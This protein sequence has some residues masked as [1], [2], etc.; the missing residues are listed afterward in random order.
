MLK[1]VLGG[2]YRGH[3]GIEYEG[4]HLPEAEGVNASKRLLDRLHAEFA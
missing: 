3:L 1:I 2:G 4:E